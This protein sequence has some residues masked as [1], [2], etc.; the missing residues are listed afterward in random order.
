MISQ[1]LL[2]TLRFFR[3]YLLPLFAVTAPFALLS[4]GV[5]WWQGD[6]MVLNEDGQVQ[7][8]NA[9]TGLMM[10]LIRPFA[11][12]AL[13]TRLGG[14]QQGRPRSLADCLLMAG[15]TGPWLLIAY[16]LLGLATYAGFLM[17]ILPGIW[18][19]ARLS[20]TPFL[21]VLE[22][23]DPIAAIKGSFQRTRSVQ[24]YLIGALMLVGLLAMVTAELIGLSLFSLAGRNPASEAAVA[25]I[26]GLAGALVTVLLFRF[27]VLTGSPEES[28]EA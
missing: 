18:I 6:F 19:Y 14:I 15:A 24:W 13:V 25:L 28:G 8:I 16:V 12:A 1:R 23:Q 11:D 17:F 5:Q 22:R 2:E 26:A 27:Y 7:R 21:V 9:I 4:Q 10:L 20:L 3:R